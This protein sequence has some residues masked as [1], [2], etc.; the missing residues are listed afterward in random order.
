M[1][2]YANT[3]TEAMETALQKCATSREVT[4]PECVLGGSSAIPEQ[5]VSRKNCQSSKAFS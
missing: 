5:I 1:S 4:V 3:S 2:W